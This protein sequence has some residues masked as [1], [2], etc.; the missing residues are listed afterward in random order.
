MKKPNTYTL[1]IIGSHP[2][3]LPLDRLALY[4]AELAKLLGDKEKIHFDKVSIGSAALKVWAEPEAAPLV[5]K[6]VTAAVS[7]SSIA[8][9]EALR[10]LVAINDLLIVD[11]KRAELKNPEGAVIYPFPG[12]KKATSMKEMLIDQECSV[13]GQVIK[14]GGRDDTIPLWLK[15]TDGVEYQ[16]TVKGE[17]LAREIATHY[18]RDPIEVSGKG[19][20]RRTTEGKWVLEQLTVKSWTPLSTDWDAAYKLMGQIASGWNDVPDIEARCSEIRKGH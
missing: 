5:S 7:N 11:G 6:R 17:Q 9:K 19:K 16:C 13:T 14:I 10:A 4:L 2:A 12:G 1:R 15:D 18:L 3:K 8:N 20:W